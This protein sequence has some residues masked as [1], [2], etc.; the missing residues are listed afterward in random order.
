MHV[1][2]VVL[3]ILLAVVFLLAGLPKL[4]KQQKMVDSAEHLG[5]SVKTFQLIGLLE[6]AAVVGL[7]V[8]VFV[9]APL[10]IAAAVGLAALLVGAVLAHKRAGDNLAKV[11]VF[12]MWLTVLSVVTVVLGIATLA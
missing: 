10:A 9:W 7:V 4:L 6:L 8:G 5:Y 3:A 11:A 12:P 2:F 1:T